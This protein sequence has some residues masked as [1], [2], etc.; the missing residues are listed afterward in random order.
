MSDHNDHGP[1]R[2]PQHE[3]LPA[4]V[5]SI[6]VHG[7]SRVRVDAAITKTEPDGR[8]ALPPAR[9]VTGNPPFWHRTSVLWSAVAALAAVAAVVLGWAASR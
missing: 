1:A 6:T 7:G 4:P 9:P 3:P 5:I 2:Q 8:A